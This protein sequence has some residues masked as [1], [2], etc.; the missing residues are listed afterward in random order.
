M[1]VLTRYDIGVESLADKYLEM[2]P[3]QLPAVGIV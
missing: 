1:E 3:C 2:L